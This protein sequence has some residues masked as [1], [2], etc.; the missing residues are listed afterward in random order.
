MKVDFNQYY[1]RIEHNR[2]IIEALDSEQYPNMKNLLERRG[3]L[4]KERLLFIFQEAQ[5]E[6]QEGGRWGYWFFMPLSRFAR[7]GAEHGRQKSTWEKTIILLSCLGMIEREIPT[8]ENAITPYRQAALQYA[9]EHGHE[10]ATAFI[11]VPEYTAG[12]MRYMEQKAK[13]WID[14]GGNFNHFSKSTVIDVFGHAVA[15]RVFQDERKK[16]RQTIE[17]E[18]RLVDVLIHI[19]ETEY[20]TTKRRLISAA[21]GN[22]KKKKS[23]MAATWERASKRVLRC[24]GAIHHRPTDKEKMRY[25]LAGNGWII[26]KG[27][28]TNREINL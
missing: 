18:K 8:D 21:A 12:Q 7:E 11:S 1:Q 24:A 6:N 3:G 26:T 16:P 4:I 15:D 19:L 23:V 22:D 20:Y 27:V 17:N 2:E 5:R 28:D 10:R 25:G 13:R 9:K 14:D